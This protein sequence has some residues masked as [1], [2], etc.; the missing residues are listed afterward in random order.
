M[1]S[2]FF[3]YD[4]KMAV[5]SKNPGRAEVDAEAQRNSDHEQLR[6]LLVEDVSTDAELI[7]RELR[8]GGIAFTARCIDTKEEFLRELETFKPQVILSDFSLGQ[9]NAFE[10]L[11]MLEQSGLDLPFILVTGSQSEEVAVAAI[12]KG[13]DDYILK[14]SLKRLPSAVLSALKKN[15]AERER[16]RAESA[17]RWSEEHFR[18]LI[19]NSSDIITIID[20]HG[21]VSYESPSVERV[22][23]YGPEE[24]M[25]KSGRLVHPDDVAGVTRIF[26]RRTAGAGGGSPLEYRVR[27]KDG[28]WRVLETVGKDMLEHPSVAGIVVNSRDITERKKAEEQI[29]EQAALLD[30][31]QDAILVHDL[32]QRIRLWNKSAQRFCTVGPPRRRWAEKWMNYSMKKIP[33]P[34][35]RRDLIAIEKGEWNG[36]LEQTTKN[37]R[38][39]TVESRWTV[40]SDRKNEA[41]GDPRDQHGYH[42]KESTGSAAPSRPADGKHRNAGRRHCA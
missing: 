32:E 15:K 18:S 14:G 21:R 17:L 1:Y 42:R 4:R 10:A 27:H 38:E 9:F 24:L 30:K 8:K 6:V 20:R 40:V 35:R 41:G 29:R 34:S 39:I 22:L 19:E 2:L 5:E 13:A 37:G 23:G 11:E 31:A 33:S 12:K 7:K 16:A 3:A 36:E 28:S 26:K 25:G